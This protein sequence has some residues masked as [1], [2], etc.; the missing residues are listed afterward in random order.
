MRSNLASARMET[1][2]SSTGEVRVYPLKSYSGKKPTKRVLEKQLPK[3]LCNQEIV[4]VLEDVFHQLHAILPFEVTTKVS[5][6]HSLLTFYLPAGYMLET[7]L[8]LHDTHRDKQRI[9]RILEKIGHYLL[10]LKKI[11]I[12]HGRIEYSSIYITNNEEIYLLDNAIVTTTYDL[13][14]SQLLD[15]KHISRSCPIFSRAAL[16][17]R[18][19]EEKDDYFNLLVL[20]YQLLTDQH[21]FCDHSSKLLNTQNLQIKPSNYLNSR[22]LNFVLKGLSQKEGDLNNIRDQY[23]VLFLNKKDENKKNVLPIPNHLSQRLDQ[24]VKKISTS[25]MFKLIALLIGA[26]LGQA[27]AYLT[28]S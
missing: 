21:P 8:T 3:Y 17:G 13:I 12:S 26:I 20:A 9:Y 2:Y 27:A 16:T 1:Y 6:D 18:R 25:W 23:R 24:P 10:A 7:W 19:A 14:E 28:L 5:E 11:D 4:A 22:Q 15:K